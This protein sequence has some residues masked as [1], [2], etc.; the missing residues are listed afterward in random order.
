[1]R[2]IC[3]NVPSGFL[4]SSIGARELPS[5]LE[6]P[7]ATWD[8]DNEIF[9]REVICVGGVLAANFCFPGSPICG[10]ARAGRGPAKDCRIA[11]EGPRSELN[12]WMGGS[13]MRAA[14]LSDHDCFSPL[15]VSPGI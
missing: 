14:V 2:R 15:V 1:M 11:G 6:D 4:A 10:E 3:P 13:G 5:L 7:H 8:F 9:S 12:P